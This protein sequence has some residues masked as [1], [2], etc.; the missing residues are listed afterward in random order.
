MHNLE[1][2]RTLCYGEI[3]ANRCDLHVSLNK[4]RSNLCSDIKDE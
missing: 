3:V 4:A 2:D 1:V